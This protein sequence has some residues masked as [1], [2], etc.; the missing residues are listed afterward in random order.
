MNG[1]KAKML[2]AMVYGDNAFR[3]VREY[4]VTFN[5]MRPVP[6]T[7]GFNGLPMMGVAQTIANAPG[8]LR[9][10]YRMLKGLAKRTPATA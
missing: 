10:K 3:A 8:S 4:V 5:R 2:R 9:A 1:K 7:M 6:G